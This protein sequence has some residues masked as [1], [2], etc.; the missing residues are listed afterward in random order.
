[1][2]EIVRDSSS[3]SWHIALRRPGGAAG[4]QADL[5]STHEYRH[6][7]TLEQLICWLGQL[8]SPNADRLP[9]RPPG[10]IR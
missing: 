8:D 2:H 1:M 10:G 4:W 3:E 7:E 6:F 5:L 9:V